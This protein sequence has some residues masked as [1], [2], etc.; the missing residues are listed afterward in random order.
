MT[1]LR[2]LVVIL[3]CA[4]LAAGCGQ[5][6]DARQ[7]Q[8]NNG[9][10]Y[11]VGDNDP[12][13][14]TVTSYPVAQ[15]ALVS[16]NG[17]CSVPISH[18]LIDGSVSCT[19][20]KGA[21]LYEGSWREGKKDG[22]EKVWFAQTGSAVSSGEWKSGRKSGLEQRF[23]PHT[24]KL[25]SEIHWA[26]NQKLGRERHWDVEGN[27]LLVD[28]DWSD[29]KKTGSSKAGEWEESYVNG[30][31]HGVR[32]HYVVRDSEAASS[33]LGEEQIAQQ[34]GGGVVSGVGRPGFY[35]SQEENWT[36]G[37]QEGTSRLLAPD[38]TVGSEAQYK[39]G[40]RISLREW[41]AN[42]ILRRE[43]YF[44]PDNHDL[45]SSWGGEAARRTYDAQGKLLDSLCFH[46]D[47]SVLAHAFPNVSNTAV[48]R[49]VTGAADTPSSGAGT[50][51]HV[52]QCVFPKTTVAKNGNLELRTP[53][54]ILSSFKSKEGEPLKAL[55][56]FKVQAEE[57]PFI[58]L[59]DK[60]TGKPIGWSKFSDFELKDLRNCNL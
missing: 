28:L 48:P 21:K 26:D 11:K 36:N 32:R 20:E 60:D 10:A 46:D 3:G 47:C 16:E 35:V 49:E 59:A 43:S 5:K 15:F 30:E 55:T 7:V 2:T 56:A 14:G 34:L 9:L 8:Q 17:S 18:G 13:S 25:I 12:F 24:N 44:E 38:G 57:G 1:Q 6:I 42:R 31:L 27:I 19:T 58:Q 39:D 37:K 52:G 22:S 29:G 4:V 45:P 23:N 41:D 40:K 51:S 54:L 50:G 33:F 53:I